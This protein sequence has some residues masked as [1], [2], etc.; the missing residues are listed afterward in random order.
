ASGVAAPSSGCWSSVRRRRR[1]GPVITSALAIAPP[2]APVQAP[3]LAL[4]LDYQP[5]TVLRRKAALTG[6]KL[7]STAKSEIRHR[8]LPNILSLPNLGCPFHETIQNPRETRFT[9]RV[10]TYLE[11]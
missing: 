1:S 7:T 9:F 11:K 6:G 4:M 5:E 10:L 8:S 2:L 3:S